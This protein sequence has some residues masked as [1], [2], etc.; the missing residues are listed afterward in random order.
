MSLD[1]PVSLVASLLSLIIIIFGLVMV[2]VRL[3][4]SGWDPYTVQALGLVLLLPAILVM[5]AYDLLSDEIIAT[6]LGVVAGYVFG[7]GHDGA[8][9]KKESA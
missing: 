3:W 5:A 2:G 4:R 7:R 8:S 6:L 9:E 1:I